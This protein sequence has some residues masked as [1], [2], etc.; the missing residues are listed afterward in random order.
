MRILLTGAT[1]LVGQGVLTQ[2]LLA[3]D[4]SHVGALGR[5]P[6]GRQHPRLEDIVAPDLADLRSVE[7][8][9]QPYDACFYCA[10]IL[11]VGVS[12][13]QFR[14]VTFELTLHVARTLARLNPGLLFAYVSGAMSD[15]ASRVMPLRVKGETERALAEVPLRTVMIRPGGIRPADGVHSTHSAR[16]VL[17]R[18]AGPLMGLGVTLA[19]QLMTTGENVGRAMLA[20]ARMPQPPAV[21]ENARI[22]QLGR[23]AAA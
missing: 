21:V 17:Y 11:P 20:V 5:R 15:P 19:P 2:C 16:D 7:P 8:R 12:E 6:S 23:D 10:G 4:V 9:L 22:N 1:G 3:E 18:L 14:H 13:A